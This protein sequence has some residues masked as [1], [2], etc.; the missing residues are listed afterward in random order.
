[1][2][3]LLVGFAAGV[4]MF[5][6]NLTAGI[7]VIGLACAG[8]VLG[9]AKRWIIEEFCAVAGMLAGSVLGLFTFVWS[10]DPTAHNLWP[11]ELAMYAFMGTLAM[12]LLGGIGALVRRLHSRGSAESPR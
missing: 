5:A 1:M 3:G 4:L 8:V 2:K 7:G 11:L 10:R 6:S 12:L 9:T